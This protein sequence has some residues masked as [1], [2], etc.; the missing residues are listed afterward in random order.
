MVG[1][2]SSAIHLSHSSLQDHHHEPIERTTQLP[3]HQSEQ[4]TRTVQQPRLQK[5]LTKSVT[6]L[7]ALNPMASSAKNNNYSH[8]KFNVPSELIYTQEERNSK[9]QIQNFKVYQELRKKMESSI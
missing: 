7:N 3:Y 5:N 1:P 2:A 4:R 6:H 9:L 8:L